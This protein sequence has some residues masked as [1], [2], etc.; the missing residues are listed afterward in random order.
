MTPTIS[1]SCPQGNTQEPMRL[2]IHGPRW[3]NSMPYD[4]HAMTVVVP[5]LID[6][7][8]RF[9]ANERLNRFEMFAPKI[10]ECA[11]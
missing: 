2:V 4:A 5:N 11:P 9:E 8:W 10:E 7:G 1:K 3:K 6:H